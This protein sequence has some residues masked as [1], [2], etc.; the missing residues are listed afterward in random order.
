M[1]W[2]ASCG[3]RA[4]EERVAD[5]QQEKYYL[6]TQLGKVECE[7]QQASISQQ[8]LKK[9]VSELQGLLDQVHVTTAEI[10]QVSSRRL[11]HQ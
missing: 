9:R 4:G 5:L 7:L 6:E 2:L 1:T 3:R 10:I 8:S 11:Q